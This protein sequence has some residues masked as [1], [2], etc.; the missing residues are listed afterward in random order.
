MDKALKMGKVSASGS[1]QLFIGKVLSTI[2]LAAGSIIVGIF[3]SESDYG[4]YSIA[5]IPAMTLLLFQDWGISQALIKYCASL[6]ATKKEG[7]LRRII[8]AGLTFNVTTALALTGLSMLAAGFLASGIFNKPE[9]VFLIT[10]ASLNILFIA[11]LTVSQ[12][13]FV[14]FERMK[15]CTITTIIY[16]I[17]QGLLSPLLVYL[18]YGALGAVVGSAVAYAASGIIAVTALYIIIYKKLK[19]SAINKTGLLKIL[20]PML[21]Y[22]VP[23]AIAAVLSGGLTQFSSFIMASTVDAAAIGNYRIATNFAVLLTFF[24]AP[25]NT[26]LFPAFSKL[27]PA[28]E[29]QL[30]K[31]VFS[32]S[33]K[34]AALFLAPA[35]LAMIVLSQPIVSTIYG[36]KWLSAPLFLSFYV[37]TNLFAILG[38]L[39]MFNLLSGLG[40]TR[41]LMKLNI[42]TLCVGIPLAFLLIPPF[43]IIGL[44]LSL[45]L[46]SI[47]RTFVGLRWIWKRY[48]AK[49]EFNISA[50]IFLASILAAVPTFLF[51]QFFSYAAWLMLA[52]GAIIFLVIFFAAVPLVGAISQTDINNLRVMFSGLGIVSK[53]IDIP[54]I[55]FEKQLN[56]L[57]EN[58]KNGLKV[59]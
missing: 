15:L 17:F 34:Y 37:I 19:P 44:I 20:K 56:L 38:T 29:H 3:I 47:P 16:A 45:I 30:I 52:G 7:D 5:L 59:V 33:V 41:M 22:G 27:N 35:T 58:R 13:I 46:A 23:L 2:I 54:L 6:R 42:L 18:G 28:N 39:S 48:G 31:T 12:S 36:G 32:S 8:V 10:V 14:G 25:I 26:V 55:I 51:L 1:F 49:A 4:L 53:I 21:T 50:R 24:E 43:G 40:E 9:S 57:P 11:L